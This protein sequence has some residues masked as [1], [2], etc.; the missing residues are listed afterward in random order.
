MTNLQK[1]RAH[2]KF[3]EFL[4]VR[5]KLIDWLVEVFEAFAYKGTNEYSF[6]RAVFLLDLFI[7]QG[8]LLDSNGD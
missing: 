7:D 3:T 2:S 8:G 4:E 5:A 1:L 6:F